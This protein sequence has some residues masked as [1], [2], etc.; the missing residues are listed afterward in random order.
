MN[1]NYHLLFKYIL[2]GDASTFL[3]HLDAGKSS[4]LMRFL[5]GKFNENY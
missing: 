3:L 5:H 2:V 1:N 4:L